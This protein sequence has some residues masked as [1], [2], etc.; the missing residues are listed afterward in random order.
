MTI[1]TSHVF[2]KDIKQR[3]KKRRKPR[4]SYPIMKDLGVQNWCRRNVELE[5]NTHPKVFKQYEIKKKQRKFKFDIL[6]PLFENP[7]FFNI[8]C[9]KIP[10]TPRF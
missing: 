5:K 9:Q 10:Q 1:V 6:N 3:H 2:V 7:L 8:K 4:S